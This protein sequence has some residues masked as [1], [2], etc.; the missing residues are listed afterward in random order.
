MAPATAISFMLLGVAFILIKFNRLKI[1][2]QYVLH[3]VSLITF[4]A[5][6][7]YVFGIPTLYKLSFYTTMAVHTSVSLFVLS[8]YISMINPDIGIT[9]LFHARGIGNQMARRLFPKMMLALVILG[10]LR[11][12]V[13]RLQIIGPEFAISLFAISFTLVGI[14]LIWDSAILLNKIDRKRELAENELIFTNQNLEQIVIQRTQDLHISTEKS[15]KAEANLRAIFNSA[16]VAIIET[17]YDGVIRN[18]N[19]SGELLLGY[20]AIEIINNKTLSMFHLEE[21]IAAHRNENSALFGQP[22]DGLDV[23]VELAKQGSYGPQ[24]WTYVRKDGSVFPVQLIVTPIIDTSGA[25]KG[26]VAIATDISDLEK[27]KSKL[28]ALTE[29]LQHQNKQLLHFAHITSHN[30]RS[31]AHNLN[32][33]LQMHSDSA[34]QEERDMLTCHMQSLTLHLCETLDQLIDSL[35]VQEDKTKQRKTTV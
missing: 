17:D 11:I 30:L 32:A 33:I 6:I 31:P 19:Q 7:G 3:F 4:V 25:T 5:V 1:L 34:D 2:G 22:G 27:A 35:K 28:E 24:K 18:F 9:W 20:K 23:F 26:F 8:I 14:F 15:N 10:F 12:E 29:R 13:H 16:L 21:E